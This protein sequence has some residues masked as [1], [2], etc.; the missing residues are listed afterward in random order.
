MSITFNLW[1]ID[2]GFPSG[3]SQ[4]ASLQDVD[5]VLHVK[6]QVLDAA[7]AD[8]RVAEFREKG[9]LRFDTVPLVKE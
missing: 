7:Q 5:W 9:L 8:A 6:D 4:R 3:D 2:G 1:F